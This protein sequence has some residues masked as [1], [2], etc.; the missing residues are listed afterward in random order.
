MTRRDAI[1]SYHQEIIAINSDWNY[2]QACRLSHN[3][4]VKSHSFI[5]LAAL[6]KLIIKRRLSKDFMNI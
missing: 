2:N 4:H 3:I 6:F 5:I 1:H